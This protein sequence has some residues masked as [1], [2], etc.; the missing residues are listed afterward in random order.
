MS[1]VELLQ[2]ADSV[3]ALAGATPG[4]N[5]AFFEYLTAI[6]YAAGHVPATPEEWVRWVER[7]E[8]LEPAADWLAREPDDHWDLFHPQRPLGQNAQL[9]PFLDQHGVGP[10][11][12]VIERAGDYNQFFDKVHLHDPDPVPPDVAFRAMLTQHVYGLGGRAMAKANWLG[13]QLTYQAV[14]RLS[15]RIRV[16]AMGPTLGDTLRLN[17]VPG[18]DRRATFNYSWTDGRRARRTFRSGKKPRLPDGRADLH[19][20]LGRS[21][22]LRP[23]L[24]GRRLMVDRVLM[25][26]GELLDSLPPAYLQDAVLTRAGKT[27]GPLRPSADRAVWRE[28]HALYA[29]AADRTKGA[30]LYDRLANLDGRKV[31]LWTVGL[32]S[33]KSAA[34]TWVSESFPYTPGLEVDLKWAADA[35][36]AMCE[37]ASKALYAA[38]ATARDEVY[39]NAKPAD[40]AKQIV[41]FNGARELWAG[42]AEPFHALI[43]AVDQG[44]RPDDGP[45]TAFGQEIRKLAFGALRQRL[46]SLPSSGGGMR[47]R[48]QAERQLKKQLSSARCPDY[49]RGDADE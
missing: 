22:L 43:D 2:K 28:A 47:A 31:D 41:R 42:G 11:Q 48:V 46:A 26:A 30:D 37:Y 32:I 40:R 19:S 27:E 6:L 3:I 24:V 10:A 29:A 15:A 35:G 39:P 18:R 25:A 14:G 12:I 45:L 7:R 13:P 38:A 44:T 34:T 5:V 33:R 1:L 4:E 21:I 49:L 20:F 36:S 8:S 23:V 17:L 9:A 16:I